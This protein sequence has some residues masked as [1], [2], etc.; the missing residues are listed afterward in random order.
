MVLRQAL[1]EHRVRSSLECVPK[2]T[3]LAGKIDVVQDTTAVHILREIESSHASQTQRWTWTVQMT[4]T[5]GRCPRFAVCCSGTS[6]KFEK[7]WHWAARLCVCLAA[8]TPVLPN[9][10][11]LAYSAWLV[12][13]A[14]DGQA[15][16]SSKHMW[17]RPFAERLTCP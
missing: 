8:C 1:L 3:L 16:Y 17:G 7:A 11:R 5:S 10:T 6:G 14:N 4:G 2:R 13:M 12:M 15:G 9:T